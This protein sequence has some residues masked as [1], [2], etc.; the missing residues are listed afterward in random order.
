MLELRRQGRKVTWFGEERELPMPAGVG[1]NSPWMDI[2]QSSPSWTRN[3]KYDY[4]PAVDRTRAV[5]IPACEAWP[6]S[7]PRGQIYV[8]DGLLTHPLATLLMAR[9]WIGAPPTYVCTGWELLADEDKYIAQKLRSQGVTVEF[10]EYEGM[11]HCFAI[12]LPDIAAARRCFNRWAGFLKQTVE[13][14]E[15]IESRATTVR[16]K[17]LD[18]VELRS[19]DLS[20]MTEEDVRARVHAQVAA[21][22]LQPETTAKL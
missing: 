2:L 3:G 16:A 20:D 1:V 10:E 12:L 11:P 22:S 4:L 6:A 17:T 18:E 19:E 9:D 14:P 15:T 13:A 5:T 7:P 21:A 8:E